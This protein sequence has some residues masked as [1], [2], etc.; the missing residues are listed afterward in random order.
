MKSYQRLLLFALIVLFFTALLSP[1]AALAWENFLSANPGWENL[2]YSFGKIF[3]RMFMIC[4]IVLFFFCRPFLKLGP[5]S[6]LGLAPRSLAWTDISVGFGLALA[7]MAA[8]ALAMSL[9]GVFTPFFRLFLARSLERCATALLAAVSVGFIEEIL[10]RGVI[11]KGLRADLGRLRAYLFAGLIYS[12]IHFVKPS[13]DV[14]LGELDGWTGVRYLIGSFAPFLD[15]D[16]LFPGL[17][18]LFLIGAVLCYAFERTGTLYLSIGLHAG[19]IY[20]LKTLRVF[21]DFRRGDL[22]WLFG[23]TDP[24]VASGAVTW[25]GILLVGIAVG[26][27]TRRRLGL[28]A[29]PP[30][31]TA[32]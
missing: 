3:N 32:A 15:L 28:A 24:K 22:G 18:G 7:S 30:Q 29:D 8:L 2:R 20:S 6:D 12:A 23:S 9:A 5:V 19:W 14:A 13:S 26:W 31:P 27:L 25:I 17:V 1:W 10:F 4:G 21:G 16:D 11:F